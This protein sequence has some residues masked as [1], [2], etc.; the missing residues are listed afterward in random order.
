MSCTNPSLIQVLDIHNKTIVHR[1][2][3]EEL[4]FKISED[5]NK[6]YRFAAN[7]SQVMPLENISDWQVQKLL[8]IPCGSC[9]SCRIDYSQDWAVRAQFE[10][11]LWKH[12]YFVTLTYDDDHLVYGNQGN[13][14]L[15]KAHIDDFI[16]TLRN[17]FKKKHKFTGIRYL[18]CGE[19]NSSGERSLNPHYHLILF[20]CP[21]FDLTIDFPSPEGGIIHK[22]NGINMPMFY[23]KLIDDIWAKGF[24]SIDD[25][26]FNTEAYVS[27]YILK[28]QKGESSSIYSEAFGVIPPFLRMSNKPGIGFNAFLLDK[29]KYVIDPYVILSKPKGPALKGL[30]KYFKRK[31]FEIDPSL[32]NQFEENAKLNELRMRSVRHA[33]KTTS[34]QQKFAKDSKLKSQQSIFTRNN[35]N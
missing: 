12:N 27:Q 26:N 5:L 7:N 29:D 24:I 4:G 19:Y 6:A 31:L 10:S 15:V 25:A 18:L 16:A 34:N 11:K 33:Y 21:L 23:S 35:T 14:T 9:L 1:K 17:Y 2:R 20:N 13:P 3:L 22:L 30:P 28:K 32:R 8:E